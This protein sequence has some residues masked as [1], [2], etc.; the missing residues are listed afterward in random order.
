MSIDNPFTITLPL[1]VASG[2]TAATT[3][4]GA[5]SSLGVVGST[6]GLRTLTL[7]GVTSATSVGLPSNSFISQIYVKANNVNAVTGGLKFGS[8][9]GAVDIVAALVVAASVISPPATLLLTKFAA[10]QTVFI[11]AVAAWNS[12]NV[13]ITIVYGQL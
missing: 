6:V 12:A 9:S 4:S 5:L 10:A 3:T 2:G 13:D 11:D 1:A 8:T 7:S